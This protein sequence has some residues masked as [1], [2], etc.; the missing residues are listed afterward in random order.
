MNMRESAL[1]KSLRRCLPLDAMAERI[2]NSVGSAMPDVIVA[3]AGKTFLVELKVEIDGV[4]RAQADWAKRWAEA[5][6][7][8]WFLI[9]GKNRALHLVPGSSGVRL[10]RSPDIVALNW[11]VGD[12]RDAVAKMLK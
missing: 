1:W 10:I 2:E 4:S 7:V 5:G 8:S 3:H 6:G 11:R 12:M 9:S